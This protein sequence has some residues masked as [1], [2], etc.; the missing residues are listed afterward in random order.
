MAS[1]ADFENAVVTEADIKDAGALLFENLGIALVD[2][3][4]GQLSSMETVVADNESPIPS[5][6]PEEYVYAM[7]D[8]DDY[9]PSMIDDLYGYR[10]AI[11]SLIQNL[12]QPAPDEGAEAEMGVQ[13][14]YSDTADLT[15]GPRA[16]R[17][18]YS[19]CNGNGIR[20]AV[21]DT[22][23][24]LAHPDFAGRSPITASFVPGES[25]QDGHGHGTH[26]IGTACGPKSPAGTNRRYGVAT[27]ATILAGKVL[28]HA[29]SGTDS[30][31]LAGINWGL[32]NN[33]VIISMSLGARVA[34]GQGFKM[35]Y[36]QAARNALNANS[37]IVAA[38]DNNGNNVPVSS[39]ANCPSIMA[40]GALN[41]SL[42]GEYRRARGCG[43][44]QRQDAGQVRNLERHQHDHAARGRLRGTV[45]AEPKRPRPATMEQVARHG[46][47]YRAARRAVG[48][49]PGP[50]AVVP[51]RHCS[52]P[53][54]VAPLAAIL[55]LPDRPALIG[56]RYRKPL[57]RRPRRGNRRREGALSPDQPGIMLGP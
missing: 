48:R 31:I 44:F 15:W 32:Q 42:Q 11:D 18:A 53:A 54:L 25:V 3:D 41:S 21:L 40:V 46:P 30:W 39:P 6:E 45:G 33:A 1:T 55:A 50:G 16:T 9:P 5:V 51:T 56:P 36:E 52:P 29:G 26:C 20:V 12:D 13:A 24:D 17:A 22:G 14:T 28:N 49:R 38:A 8:G 35:A 47:G 4:P 57:P 2:V 37:L 43:V 7:K 10:D 27:N 34:I 19:A 23:F